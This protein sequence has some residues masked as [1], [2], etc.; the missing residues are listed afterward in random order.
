MD[1]D[2]NDQLNATTEP[3]DKRDTQEIEIVPHFVIEDDDLMLGGVFFDDIKKFTDHIEE[4]LG[5]IAETFEGNP[6]DEHSLPEYT[7][8]VTIHMK[9][10]GYASTLPEWEP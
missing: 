8:T 2:M 3:S 9:P 7:C 6:I 1:E 10:K 5:W 4:Q